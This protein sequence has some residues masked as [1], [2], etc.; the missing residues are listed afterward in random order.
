MKIDDFLATLRN[1]PESVQFEDAMAVIAANYQFTPTAFSNGDLQNA[2]DQNQ[3]SCK[4]L[5]FAKLQ[6]L[7][8]EAT[9]ACFGKYY[10]ED[11]LQNPEGNDHQNIRNFMTTGWEGVSFEGEPL[12]A[13]QT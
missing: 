11:V 9:L 10:R 8:P 5:A 2:P 1:T 3:G 12:A 7:S 6:Q 13:N 4:L